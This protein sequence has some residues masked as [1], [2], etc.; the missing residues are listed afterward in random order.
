MAKATDK[1]KALEQSLT[2]A[3]GLY[4]G[5]KASAGGH[6]LHFRK[7]LHRERLVI[8]VYVDGH[9]RGEWCRVD[10]GGAPEHP[11][12]RLW[13]PVRTRAYQL[14]KYAA[15]KRAFGKREADRMTALR[16]V[17]VL[18]Y[19]NSPRSLVRHLKAAF[20]DLELVDSEVPA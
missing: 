4:G 18:P 3:A 7:G 13:R 14:K 10:E 16:T 15:L 1:W 12:G 2:G 9:M 5:V 11:E 17:A 19:W 8:E 6:E 20:P